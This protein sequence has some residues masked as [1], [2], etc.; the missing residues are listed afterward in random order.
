M[1]VETRAGR[2]G[3][4]T[5]CPAAS[6]R[7]AQA[8]FDPGSTIGTLSGGQRQ[9][10][11]IARSLAN[12]PAL[13]L[14]DEPTGALDS[15]GGDEVMELF[16][17]LHQSGRTIVMVTHEPLVAGRADRV[18]DLADGRTVTVSDVVASDVVASDVG[19]AVVGPTGIDR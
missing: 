17:R 10:L 11:A 3:F 15:E 16:T 4:A 1:R 5:H 2:R 9:R 13:L 18:V 6:P 14:A 7:A 19:G 8:P 12:E